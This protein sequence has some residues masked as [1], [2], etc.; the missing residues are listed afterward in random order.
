MKKSSSGYNKTENQSLLGKINDN[1][2]QLIK[3]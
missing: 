3:K 1:T 2:I